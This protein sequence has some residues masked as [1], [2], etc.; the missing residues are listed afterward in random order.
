MSDKI[1]PVT[2]FGKHPSS[3]EYLY[4]GEHSTFMRTVTE[5]VEKGFETFL[6]NRVAN[7]VTIQH[8]CFFNEK[9]DSMICGSMKLSQ[10]KR[11]RKYPLLIAVEVTQYSSMFNPYEAVAF[12]KDISRKIVQIFHK[13]CDLETLKSALRDLSIYRPLIRQDENIASTILMNEDF[14]EA[15]FFYRPL[16]LNDFIT[17]MR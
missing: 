11:G 13:D 17:N 14:T 9:K 3:S 2:L 15:K 8:F 7:S 6:Q 5:W 10:D 4:L 1:I 12:S 16:E